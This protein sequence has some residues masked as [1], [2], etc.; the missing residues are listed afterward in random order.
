MHEERQAL[1]L[2][3]LPQLE[4]LLQRVDRAFFRRA[5]DGDD[6]VDGAEVAQVLVQLCLEVGQ[7][8]AG[9]VV[10]FD[11]DDVAGADAGDG[12]GWR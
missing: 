4:D 7:V 3:F 2:E 8:D 6:G 10:D 5:D 12:W 11:A 1:C 9:G